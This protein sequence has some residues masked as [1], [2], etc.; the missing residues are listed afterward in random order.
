MNS[1]SQVEDYLHWSLTGKHVLLS[2]IQLTTLPSF[3]AAACL[4]CGI[5][6]TERLVTFALESKWTPTF[7]GHGRKRYALWRAG[8]YWF[9]ALLRLLYMLIAMSFNAALILVVATALGFGQFII[10]YQSPPH[11]QQSY[12]S[13]SLVEETLFSSEPSDSSTVL[14]S[15]PKPVSSAARTRPRSKSKPDHIFI[16]PNQSNIARAD[17]AALQLGLTGSTDRVEA[18]NG[19]YNKDGTAWEY[20]KGRDGARALLGHSRRKPLSNSSSSHRLDSDSEDSDSDVV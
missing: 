15:E 4:T 5:C 14:T 3:L 9:A 20:G 19:T 10:E 13:Y 16:H 7:I 18:S 17:A 1:T 2:S 11:Y 6:L 8:L 12:N